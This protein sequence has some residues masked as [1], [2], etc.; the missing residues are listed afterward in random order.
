MDRGAAHARI[1]G[2]GAARAGRRDD[3]DEDVEEGDGGEENAGLQAA[4]RVLAHPGFGNAGGL[5]DV[6]G[7]DWQD[8]GAGQQIQAGRDVAVQAEA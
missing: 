1:D 7:L 6:R 8:P 3:E 2:N 4:R 5:L